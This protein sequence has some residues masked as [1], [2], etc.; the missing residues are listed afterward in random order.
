MNTLI[1]IILAY[2]A[3]AILIALLCLS[4]WLKARAVRQQLTRHDGL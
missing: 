4:T 1:F 2:A 3:A